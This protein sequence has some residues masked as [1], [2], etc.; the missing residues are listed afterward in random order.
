[1]A[2]AFKGICD[3][4]AADGTVK[5][6]SAGTAVMKDIEGYKQVP[7]KRIQGWGQGLTLAFLTALLKYNCSRVV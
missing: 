5:N 7:R 3:N 1:V 4:I 6:V 2:K